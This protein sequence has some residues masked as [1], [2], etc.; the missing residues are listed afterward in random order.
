VIWACATPAELT[1]SVS[2]V[3]API[4]TAAILFFVNML[5]SLREL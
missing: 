3:R 2:A 5:V 1:L 4:I